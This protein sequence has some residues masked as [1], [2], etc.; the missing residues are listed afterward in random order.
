MFIYCALEHIYFLGK[1]VDPIL[2]L[3]YLFV[4]EMDLMVLWLNLVLE[5]DVLGCQYVDGLLHLVVEVLEGDL[6]LDVLPL[7]PLPV[8][9]LLLQLLLQ[10]I[11]KRFLIF[12]RMLHSHIQKLTRPLSIDMNPYILNITAK[13]LPNNPMHIEVHH[14]PLPITCQLVVQFTNRVIGAFEVVIFDYVSFHLL[15]KMFLEVVVGG[16]PGHHFW[17]VFVVQVEIHVVLL[18]FLKFDLVP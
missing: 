2:E 6:T 13:M 4:L 16:N 3:F 5:T 10:K 1:E 15:L 9:P 17:L 8:L 18:C 12:V 11:L 14:L 7:L